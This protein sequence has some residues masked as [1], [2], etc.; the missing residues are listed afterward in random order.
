[1][2]LQSGSPFAFVKGS[3]AS[4][5]FLS[6]L[7]K[8]LDGSEI[9]LFVPK[10]KEKVNR[11]T[12]DGISTIV[13]TSAGVSIGII[14][15]D[16][17]INGGSF[18][19]EVSMRVAAFLE[20]MAKKGFPVVVLFNTIGVRIMEGRSVFHESFGLMR[21]FFQFAEN[22]LLITAIMG[23]C[24]GLGA[25][26]FG[27]GHYRLALAEGL[28]N[29]TGPEVIRLFF[30]SAVDFSD[31]AS[32]QKQV[33]N[34][35]L[36]QEVY[37][38]KNE[39]IARIRKILSAAFQQ[40]DDRFMVSKLTYKKP[41]KNMENFLE[42]C[43]DSWIEMFIDGDAIVRLFACRKGNK[44]FGL[45]IN[46]PQNPY[47]MISVNGLVKYKM[48]LDLFKMFKFP[49]VA[50]SDTPG[51]DP[52]EDQVVKDLVGLMVEVGQRIIYYPHGSM[53][54]VI[55]RC[56]G[57]ATTLCFPKNFN[58]ERSY[59]LVDAK[60][61]IMAEQIVP[62]L[63]EKSPRLLQQWMESNTP[64]KARMQDL[65]DEG[66]TDAVITKEELPQK[67]EEFLNHTSRK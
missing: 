59:L 2:G 1:M 33:N 18:G 55:G 24:L 19:R 5:S 46:P 20:V 37:S 49:I 62:Q 23:K 60:L 45:F 32:I 42:T 51:I 34:T 38:D 47:N 12:L 54:V 14:W 50:L 6:E 4:Y 56:Y 43:A 10:N 15:C 8:L 29:L 3:L 65:I 26:L 31:L 21:A 27:I 30:G 36:V 9:E 61:D 39:I 52:R 16:F 48:G 58:A 13:G 40:F 17:R 53:G 11:V 25:P 28:V 57:G 35:Q 44:K 67:I 41:E 64:E 22:H 66:I 7:V 63:F